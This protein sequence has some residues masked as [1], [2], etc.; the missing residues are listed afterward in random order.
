M[1]LILAL[2]LAGC[3]FSTTEYETCETNLQCQ[4]A[5][6]WGHACGEEGLCSVVVQ[7]PRC[8]VTEPADLFENRA[9]YQD[10]IVL[11]VQFDTSQF[12]LEAQAMRLAVVQANLAEGLD[13]R[14]YAVV[15]CTNEENLSIDSL[16]SDG[17]NEEVTRYLADEIGVSA[18]MGP[19]TSGRT[20]AAYIVAEAY[21]TVIISPS[22]TS[23]ALTDL[24][25][26]SC[27]DADPGLLWR[28]APPDDLQGKVMALDMLDRDVGNV[29]V[30]FQEGP[31]GAGLQQAFST[32]FTEGGGTV[33]AFQFT[34]G[35]TSQRDTA[36][37]DVAFGAYD[38]VVFISA[39]KTD[40]V[41]FLLGAD[42]A[43]TFEDAGT[44]IFL[45]D[46]AYDESIFQDA[47]DADSVFSLVRGTRPT[48]DLG[49]TYT[50]FAIAF[51]G[52]YGDDASSSGFTAYAYD[53]AWMV[54]Y[55]TAWSVY[56]DGGQV[57]GTGIARGMRQV[58][59]GDQVEVLATSW[60]TVRANFAEGRAVDL[61]GASGAI[62]FDDTTCETSAPIEV[63]SVSYESGEG[64]VFEAITTVQPG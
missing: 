36:I 43:G 60:T 5:F 45:A 56:Q 39:D 2:G 20:E 9:D 47:A 35:N 49:Q 13:G 34:E 54:L 1:R 6:G 4:E 27:S 17:A 46:G 50:S 51:A 64:Y 55:G 57:T 37:S 40:I 19:A 8:E 41:A 16:D 18:I 3:S 58:S 48:T 29:A 21:D 28:T 52:Y 42:A 30:I 7:H 63:W 25:G 14:Q 24:D 11:G 31:Y 22:A 59:E 12:G 61:Q 38:E 10:S 53:A 33:E 62:N 23:P 32:N 15:Q 44:G 26:L